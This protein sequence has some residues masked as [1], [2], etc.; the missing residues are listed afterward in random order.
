V[1]VQIGS[2]GFGQAV[3]QPLPPDS[4]TT[5]RLADS[6]VAVEPLDTAAVAHL[7]DRCS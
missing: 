3:W 1:G 6:A 4:V 7:G 2:T 5:A